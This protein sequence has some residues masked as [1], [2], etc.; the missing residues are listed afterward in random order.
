MTSLYGGIVPGFGGGTIKVM[1]KSVFL[2][3]RFPLVS[4]LLIV[5]LGSPFISAQAQDEPP[6]QHLVMPGD[7][8]TALSLRY[9]VPDTILRRQLPHLNRWREPVIGDVIEIPGAQPERTGRLIRS[10]AGGT[11]STAVVEGLNPWAVALSNG[12]EHPYRPLLGRPLVVPSEQILREYPP[13]FVSLDLSHLPGKAGEGMAFRAQINRSTLSGRATLGTE[14]GSMF[15]NL[16][17]NRLIGLLATGAFFRPFAPELTIQIDGEPLW[18]QPWRFEDKE[19]TFNQITLTGE[20]ANISQEA[21]R[22][23]RARLFELWAIQTPNPQWRTAVSEPVNSYLSYSSFY[24]ARRSY[25][26]GP[27][28]SY[29]EG[30]DFAAYGGTPVFAPVSGTIVLAETL[31]VRGG[32]VIID[33]GLGIYSGY[34]HMSEVL[35][36]AG[37]Y[38][39]AGTTIGAVGTTGLSTG[40]HLHWDLLVNGIWVDPGAFRE[41]DMA[42]WLLDGWGTP[43]QVN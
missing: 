24:G 10:F 13:G 36:E 17:Q 25:N 11:W 40:N 7:T 34:Y 2:S 21:I 39:E 8:W 38:I 23:E 22:E 15:V 19:W 5:I 6:V 31:Y 42:C 43:C 27:Y 3:N 37:T 18:V 14:T 1:L 28:S 30:L 32:A 4:F 12:I 33:H 26:G 9:G 29:H 35:V 16:E 20:A 41:R